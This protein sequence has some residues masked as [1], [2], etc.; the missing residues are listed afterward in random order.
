MLLNFDS[1]VVVVMCWFLLQW[2]WWWWSLL[3]PLV[4]G[5]FSRERGW[6]YFGSKIGAWAKKR[7]RLAQPSAFCTLTGFFEA[8]CLSARSSLTRAVDETSTRVEAPPAGAAAATAAGA[9]P[10]LGLEEGFAVPSVVVPL[11]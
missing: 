4:L 1:V 9:A 3:P 2:W 6:I 7:A 10:A 5:F 8:F 11:E